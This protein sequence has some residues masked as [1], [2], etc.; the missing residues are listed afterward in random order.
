M[1]IQYTC[2]I[3][4]INLTSSDPF[5]IGSRQNCY[6]FPVER[7][8]DLAEARACIPTTFSTFIYYFLTLSVAAKFRWIMLK[9]YL[10]TNS[11]RGFWSCLC[12][13]FL[14]IFFVYFHFLGLFTRF[15]LILIFLFAFI[16]V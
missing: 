13:F 10:K 3:S 12:S 7:I 1:I 8:S 11:Y 9:D 5:G 4:K 16:F 6:C 15:I 14:F 2:T